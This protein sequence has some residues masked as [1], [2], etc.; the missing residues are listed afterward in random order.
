MLQLFYASF[1]ALLISLSTLTH[2]VELEKPNATPE[3]LKN[4][5]ISEKLGSQIDLDA[6]RFTDEQ[7]VEKPLRSFIRPTKPVIL[8][9][10]YYSCPNLCGMLLNGL[11]DTLKTLD[12]TAA[13]QFDIVSVSMDH[14]EKS[15]LA[16]KKKTNVLKAYGRP[17]VE[18]G[19]HFLTGQ[20]NQI[21]KLADQVGFGFQYNAKQ[22]EYAH[23]AALII[24]TPEGKVS[25]YLYGVQYEKKDL[26]MAL[27]EASSG[28]IGTIVDRVLLYC[29]HYDPKIGSYSFYAFRLMQLGGLFTLI[30][31]A[32][33]FISFWTRQRRRTA[34]ILDQ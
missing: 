1:C 17:G 34:V 14:R 28:K 16:S 21:R 8:N 32:V 18:Q 2:A 6:I 23:S 25:R 7:G 29:F 24:L 13:Q 10:V 20:E 11:L 30:V 15:D 27:L 3:E 22:D 31:M 9:I 4:A 26:R 33:F 12:W 5:G 19:W